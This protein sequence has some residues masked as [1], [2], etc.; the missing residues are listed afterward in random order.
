MTES[1]KDKIEQL[2]STLCSIPDNT[3]VEDVKR[4]GSSSINIVIW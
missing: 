3:S 4:T 2:A 1:L